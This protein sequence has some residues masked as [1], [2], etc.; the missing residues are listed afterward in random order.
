MMTSVA[1]ASLIQRWK[2]FGRRSCAVLWA[3][4]L[5]GASGIFPCALAGEA[6]LPDKVQFNRDIRPILSD[7]CFKCHGPD[8]KERK[9]N[10][11]LDTPEG[12][13][14]R[15]EDHF[16]IVPGRLDSTGASPAPTRM[17]RCRR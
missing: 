8:K 6:T 1:H 16:T 12:A 9:A 2:D 11:R 5:P 13:F 7:T 4:L 17:S 14:A 3:A 10:L 15:S